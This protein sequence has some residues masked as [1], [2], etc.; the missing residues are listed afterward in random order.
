MES[1]PVNLEGSRA[2]Q[3]KPGQSGNPKGRPKGKTMKE[4]ARQWLLDMSDE[5]KRKWLK[6]LPPQVVWTMSEGQPEQKSEVTVS[7]P[8]PILPS[9]PVSND[10][11]LQVI[12]HLTKGKGA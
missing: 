6:G 5:D 3:Y 11:K 12:N 10:T 4:Y 2:T 7:A 1:N 8:I 9:R